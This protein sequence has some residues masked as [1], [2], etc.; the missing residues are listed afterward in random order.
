MGSALKPVKKK[1]AIAR[2][3][4]QVRLFLDRDRKGGR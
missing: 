4:I 2:K 3:D 1:K